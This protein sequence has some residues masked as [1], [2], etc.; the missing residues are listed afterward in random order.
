MEKDEY[1]EFILQPNQ[2]IN[3]K[4]KEYSKETKIINFPRGSK[5][6]YIDFVKEVKC[7]VISIDE[8]CPK[9]ILEITE[10]KNIVIQGDL[11]PKD[12]VLG[13]QKLKV[14]IV[15]IL[16]KFKNNKHIFN[17]SHGILPNT[18]IINVKKTINLVRSYELAR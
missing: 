18:P 4:I 2:I 12:L 8:S 17:L 1:D 3:K 10:Q 9:D 13:G 15:E 6:K 11:N 5:T 7:D 14:R 16:E